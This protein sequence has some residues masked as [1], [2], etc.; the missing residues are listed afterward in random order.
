MLLWAYAA[1]SADHYPTRAVRLIIP[2]PPAGAGDILGRMLSAKLSESFGQQFVNDNRPGGGQVI[3]TEL[4]ARANPDGHTLF[5]ASATHGINPALVKKLP[6]DSIKDFTYIL[7]LADSPLICVAN[8]GIGVSGVQELVKLAKSRPGGI[9]YGSSGPG[10][11][12]H[13]AVEL[14]KQMTGANF[15][16][17]PYKGASPALT[18]VIAGQLQFMC[19]SPLA[20]L[21]QVK[22]GRV[23]AI[24]MTGLKRSRAA[25]DVPT[26]AEQGLKGYQATLWYVLLGPAKIPEPIVKRLNSEFNRV[27]KLPDVV[28]QLAQQGGDPI[29][30]TPQDAVKFTQAEI[31]R[32]SKL[33]QDTKLAVQ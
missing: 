20:A 4:T 18:D 8:A 2:F 33:I 10:T 1:G 14:I 29:G 17:V 24:A 6:Y 28:E 9:N 27:L 23:R 26:V 19:T 13:L 12:G 15:T 22:S 7:M 32:W 30:G 11:G 25:P 16:H 31:T 3:A 5:I 21:P